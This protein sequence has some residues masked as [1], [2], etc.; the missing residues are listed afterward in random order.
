MAWINGRIQIIAVGK[1]RQKYWQSA[2][3]DFL[4]RLK[5]YTKLELTELKDIVGQ[6]IDNEAAKKKETEQLLN[7]KKN[8]PFTIAVDVKGKALSSPEFAAFIQKR[9][10]THHHIG[11]LV[12]GPLGFSKEVIQSSEASL[13]L[14]EFTFTH[15]LAR[16]LLLEQLYRAMTLLSGEKYH[17]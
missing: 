1:I 14:S 12:G 6:G 13:S 17:K 8:I 10:E 2:Q 4:E 3:K 5:H 16:V 15:E 7:I 11:F 9:I